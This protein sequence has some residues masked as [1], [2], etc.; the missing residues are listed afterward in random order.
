MAD[1]DHVRRLADALI[2]DHLDGEWGFAFDRAKRRAGMTNHTDRRIQ[3]SRHLAERAPI[4]EVQQVLLHE[5]AHAIAGYGAAHG[6]SW[7]RIARDLGY[8][9]GRLHDGDV[10]RDLA[11]WLGQC[12][13]GHVHHRF[14]APARSMS[15]ARC[16][17]S[18]DDAHRIAWRRV[19]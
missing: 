14:R 15:C 13:A 7:R 19:R 5:V 4:D 16:S 9:G 10:A 11:P 3:V 1:L 2:A 18:F 12:P 17:R 6:P 8:V